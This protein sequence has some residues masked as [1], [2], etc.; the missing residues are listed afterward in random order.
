[1]ER[2]FCKFTSLLTCLVFIFLCLSQRIIKIIDFEEGYLLINFCGIGFSFITGS[3][4]CN[5]MGIRIYDSNRLFYVG[6]QHATRGAFFRF[7]QVL[8]NSR[9]YSIYL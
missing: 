2:E 9:E 5:T 7:V 8:S 3:F 6:G 1:M 4:F